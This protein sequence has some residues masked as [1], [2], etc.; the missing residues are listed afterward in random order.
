MPTAQ[1]HVAIDGSQASPFTMP[2]MQ[3]L[4]ANGQL[5]PDTLVWK[6]GMAGWEQAQ[7]VP[8]LLALFAPPAA[9]AVPPPLP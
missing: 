2:Q 9:G 7:T 3:Q 5:K 8:E 1:F 6:Q 4:V